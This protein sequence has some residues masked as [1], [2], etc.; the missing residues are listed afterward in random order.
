M[1]RAAAA[2]AD[3]ASVQHALL[4]HLPQPQPADA[5][6]L[7]RRKWQRTVHR[8]LLPDY[9]PTMMAYMQKKVHRWPV[10]I[11]PR[12]RA[13]RA[14]KVLPVVASVAAPRVL[15]AV[16]RTLWNGW[17]TA[18]RFQRRGLD[19]RARCCYGCAAVDSIEHYAHC[20][21][22]ADFAWRYLRLPRPPTPAGR[23]ADLLLLDVACP[24]ADSGLVLRKALRTAVAYHGH[25]LWRHAVSPDPA[26]T[27]LA[28][29]QLLREMLRGHGPSTRRIEQL[30]AREHS[31]LHP[32]GEQQ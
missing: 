15:A 10:G 20:S 27:R 3:T 8:L 13:T 26:T 23:L 19:P 18:R 4:A 2:G 1:R 12:I 31:D 25:N 9:V 32:P 14:F 17:P 5:V 28:L 29:P 16:L 22:L 30:F 6:L 7:H 24:S 21:A 11:F